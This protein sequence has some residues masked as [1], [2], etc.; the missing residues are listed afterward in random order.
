MKLLAALLLILGINGQLQAAIDAVYD[1]DNGIRSRVL[2]VCMQCHSTT[3]AGGAR[4]GSPSFVNFNTYADAVLW[5]DLAVTRAVIEG[6]MPPQGVQRLNAEQ[7]AALSAWQAA[8]FPEKSAT[9]S[10]QQQPDCLFNWAETSF[11]NFFAP[12][13]LSL[14]ADPYYYRYYSQTN[15]YL[16]IAS[17]RLYYLGPV[18]SGTVADLGDVVTWYATSGC[19]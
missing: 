5:G 11:P 8:G 14:S 19:K 16:A 13:A 10:T 9:V 15:A 3:L 2:T 18:S 1:G 12:R 6:S 17:S 7:K 4:N